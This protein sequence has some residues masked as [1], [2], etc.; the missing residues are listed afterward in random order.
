MGEGGP[1]GEVQ[2][3]R[4]GNLPESRRPYS[5]WNLRYHR[6]A[7]FA[8]DPAR[9]FREQEDIRFLLSLPGVDRREVQGYF[10]RYGLKERFDELT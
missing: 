7:N 9:T 2:P 10:E 1:G 8:N 6:N 3:G 5:P 4:H